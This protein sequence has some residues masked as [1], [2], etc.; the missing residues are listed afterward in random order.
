MSARSETKAGALSLPAMGSFGPLSAW[1]D[2]F[3]DPW[4]GSGCVLLQHGFARNAHLWKPWVP[5]L[6]RRWRCI[7]PDL[8]GCGRTP[9]PAEPMEFTTDFL[10]EA[11][12]NLLDRLGIERVHYVAE[13]ASVGIGASLAACLPERVASLTL[14]SARPSV[15]AALRVHHSVGFGTWEEAIVELGTREWWVRARSTGGELVGGPVDSYLADEAGKVDPRAAIAMAHWASGWNLPALLPDIQ[16]PTLF[17]WAEGRV[18]AA[19]KELVGLVP[20]GH[21]RIVSDISSQ[22]MAYTDA[23]KVAPLVAEFLGSLPR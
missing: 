10:L 16:V 21:S 12:C 15:D 2:D 1:D 14:I 5:Y 11:T 22:L 17:V 18:S 3:T 13:G 23:D 6:G 8:P 4:L 7:R 20:D 19:Q 9:A